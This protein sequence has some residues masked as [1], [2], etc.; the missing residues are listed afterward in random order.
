[1]H[2]P[3]GRTFQGK[4]WDAADSL[5]TASFIPTGKRRFY[6]RPRRDERSESVR[7]PLK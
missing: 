4:P 7:L 3:A 6:A 5:G 1:M 2:T